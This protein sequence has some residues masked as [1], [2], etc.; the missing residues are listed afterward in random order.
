MQAPNKESHMPEKNDKEAVVLTGASA[1]DPEG[2]VSA[3]YRANASL[4]EGLMLVH[5]SEEP[6]GTRASIT[7]DRD[8]DGHADFTFESDARGATYSTT[9]DKPQLHF[10]APTAQAMTDAVRRIIQYGGTKPELYHAV[11]DFVQDPAT[12][13]LP[14]V[15]PTA[16]QR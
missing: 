15:T 7:L 6:N 11:A 16:R 12:H 14:N 1:I 8:R 2:N 5:Y 4:R 3:S 13:G 9:G 10:D